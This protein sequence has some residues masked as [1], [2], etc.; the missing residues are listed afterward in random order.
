MKVSLE[1][2]I[3]SVFLFLLIILTIGLFF[4]DKFSLKENLKN[5]SKIYFTL[6]DEIHQKRLPPN[7]L[8]SFL[9]NKNFE[10]VKNPKE[11]L[12]SLE[13]ISHKLKEGEILI[14]KEYYY[15]HII[16]PY[17]RILFKDTQT[18]IE[19]NYF[20]FIIYGVL[21]I[22]FGFI[23]FLIMKNIKDTNRLLDSRQLFLRTV[24]HELKTPIAKGKIVS[25]LI[26][27]EK[28]KN[29]II[30]IFDTLNFLIDDMAKVEQVVS[31]NFKSNL[32]NYTIDEMID[33]ACVMLLLDNV[34]KKVNKEFSSIDQFKVDIDFIAMAIK[35]LLDNGIKYSFDNKVQLVY[36]N[37]TL[38]FIS[39]GKALKK[40]I[41]NY[42]KP[43]HN[44]TKDKNHGMGLGL[45]IVYEILQ[46]HGFFLEYEYKKNQNIFRIIFS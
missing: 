11:V 41:E 42:F 24:M 7:E 28:Q 26:E 18:K 9:E 4:I 16:T 2:K 37:N 23:Y 15:I 1:S 45:Y 17:F 3:R 22:L 46:S 36:S 29:R 30:H 14:Y 35:N 19:K 44:E 12:D 6:L 43:F 10:Q 21:I 20:H 32:Y 40:P 31:K 27:E 25:E 33:S 13:T 34:E 38:E 8:I 39:N 5:Q